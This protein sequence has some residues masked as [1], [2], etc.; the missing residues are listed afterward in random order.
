MLSVYV[1][2]YESSIDKHVLLKHIKHVYDL[3]ILCF[4]NIFQ[5]EMAS[6]KVDWNE[7]L[8]RQMK[9]CEKLDSFIH[10]VM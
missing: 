8:I 4:L 2:Q 3:A 7:Q 9:S 10:S 5:T 6:L 1:L